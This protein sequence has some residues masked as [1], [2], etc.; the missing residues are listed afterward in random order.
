[1]LEN[2]EHAVRERAYAIWER[3]G[4]P[5]G[6]NLDHWFQAETE[7]IGTEPVMSTVSSPKPVTPKRVASQR[8]SQSANSG[9]RRRA[10]APL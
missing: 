10:T 3:D 8:R 4:R 1:M 9:L 7:M 5:E 6:K 2:R